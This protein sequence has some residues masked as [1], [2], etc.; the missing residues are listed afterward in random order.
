MT[1]EY[2][3]H[4][5]FCS[6]CNTGSCNIGFREKCVWGLNKKTL[7]LYIIKKKLNQILMRN[8]LLFLFFI[9]I[10]LAL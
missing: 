6:F 3:M 2:F 4:Y 9:H 10:S 8:S 7:E 1:Y 5:C